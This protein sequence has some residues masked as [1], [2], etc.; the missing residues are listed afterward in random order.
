MSDSDGHEE[1]PINESE[2]EKEETESTVSSYASPKDHISETS[3]YS[4]Q[5][6]LPAVIAESDAPTVER[7]EREDDYRDRSSEE[8]NEPVH[9]RSS[10][11]NG[12]LRDSNSQKEVSVSGF[13]ENDG[14]IE[15]GI[16]QMERSSDGDESPD[17][18]SGS[19]EMS[20]EHRPKESAPT[21]KI[22]SQ[23]A[24]EL[25]VEVCY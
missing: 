8:H 18:P 5:R 13:R 10:S 6:Y 15:W 16:P 2:E 22:L 12:E 17:D 7:L 23:A 9:S 21:R 14:E 4:E 19:E 3:G 1:E 11:Q 24:R 20:Y 25:A